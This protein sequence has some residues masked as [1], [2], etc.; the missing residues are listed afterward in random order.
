MSEGLPFC[1]YFFTLVLVKVQTVCVGLSDLKSEK[2]WENDEIS[3]QM[4]VGIGS[5]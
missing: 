1:V 2:H 4:Y 5:L 3:F